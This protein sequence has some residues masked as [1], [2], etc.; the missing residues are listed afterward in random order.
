[1]TNSIH[2]SSRRSSVDIQQLEDAP[3]K[4]RL[5]IGEGGLGDHSARCWDWPLG[6]QGGINIRSNDKVLDAW[7]D[8]RPFE[9][10]EIWVNEANL[11]LLLA[12][13]LQDV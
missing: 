11:I 5:S 2:E 9:P 12:F 1:M 4:R 13:L 7:L 3:P 8:F 10:N 6:E